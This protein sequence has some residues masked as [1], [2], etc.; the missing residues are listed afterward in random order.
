MNTAFLFS[1]KKN[2]KEGPQISPQI[3]FVMFQFLFTTV[4]PFTS[5][6]L[7]KNVLELIFK[8]VPLKESS[9]ETRHTTPEYLYRYGKGC[10]YFILILSGEATI[11]VGREKLEFPAGPFAYFGTNA[12]LCGA[13]KSE[14]VIADITSKDFSQLQRLIRNQCRQAL[15]QLECHLIRFLEKLPNIMCPILVCV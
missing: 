3:R 5:E 7:T 8:K 9:R 2:K 11:E 6:F 13:E 10:N 12:L 14:E 15:I 4:Q 1:N